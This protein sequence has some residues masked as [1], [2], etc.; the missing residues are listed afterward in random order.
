MSRILDLSNALNETINDLF[1]VLNELEKDLEWNTASRHGLNYCTG[2][3]CHSRQA[4]NCPSPE[5]FD[6]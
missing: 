2:L 6:E 5:D 3:W 4:P 1:D